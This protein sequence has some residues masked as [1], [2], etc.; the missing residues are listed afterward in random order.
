MTNAV[1]NTER[2]AVRNGAHSRIPMEAEHEILDRLSHE[3]RISSEEMNRILEHYGVLGDEEALQKGYRKRLAQRL[4]A[5]L[6][7]SEGKREVLSDNR[8]EYFV[9]R[10]CNDRKTLK[11]VQRRLLR[12]MGGLNR[13]A[14]KVHERAGILE[15][16]ID[17]LSR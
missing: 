12:E 15:R 1:Q 2:A 6:R 14:D 13:T 16:L 7:D 3:M 5:S 10:C 8:G 4:M 9:I 17:N 11:A